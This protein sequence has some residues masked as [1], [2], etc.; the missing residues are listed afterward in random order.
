[1]LVVR[2]GDR[3]LGVVTASRLL[4]ALFG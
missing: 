2:G 3:T 4:E 1:V